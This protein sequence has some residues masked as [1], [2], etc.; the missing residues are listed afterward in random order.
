MLRGYGESPAMAILT[1]RATDTGSGLESMRVSNQSSFA[2]AAWQPFTPVQP[3]P[4][5]VPIYVQF[6][7]SAGN[8]SPAVSNLVRT[9]FVPA[10]VAD[11]RTGW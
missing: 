7:D 3:W 10:G 5:G 9:M 6:R 8:I 4:L 1:L 11:T 2:G